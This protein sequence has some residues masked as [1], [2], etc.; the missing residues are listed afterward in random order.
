VTLL[1]CSSFC[2]GVYFV[3]SGCV[4]V[5]GGG[6]GA[7]NGIYFVRRHGVG[8]SSRNRVAVLRISTTLIIAGSLIS[9]CLLALVR[10]KCSFSFV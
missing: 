4:R 6:M 5:G 2:K 7:K 1:L 9:V 3:R 8:V 10:Y